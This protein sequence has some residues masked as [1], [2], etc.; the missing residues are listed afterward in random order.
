MFIGFTAG[1]ATR[2]AAKLIVGYPA[3]AAGVTH[4]AG[5]LRP[6]LILLMAWVIGFLDLSRS[7]CALIR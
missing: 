3:Y 2:P 4:C 1:V 5:V 6:V 7:A